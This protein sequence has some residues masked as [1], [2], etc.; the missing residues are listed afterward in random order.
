M[1]SKLEL[2]VNGL[3]VSRCNTTFG[4]LRLRCFQEKILDTIYKYVNNEI[5]EGTV[6]LS[7]PTGAGKTLTLLLGYKVFHEYSLRNYGSIGLYPTNELLNDQFKSIR[8]MLEKLGFAWRPYSDW[9]DN[10]LFKFINPED[11]KILVLVISGKKLSILEKYHPG[12][13]HTDILVDLSSLL[14]AEDP[15]YTVI[16]STPDLFYYLLLGIYGDKKRIVKYIQDIL[17]GVEPRITGLKDQLAR[18]GKILHRLAVKPLIFF[19]EYHSWSLLDYLSSLVLVKLFVEQ[20]SLVVLS[21]ATPLPET[22]RHL[23]GIGVETQAVIEENGSSSGDLIRLPTHLVVYGYSSSDARNHGYYGL[24]NIYNVEKL[25]PIHVKH[26]EDLVIDYARKNN[27][28]VLVVLDRISYTLETSR[29][30]G[31]KYGVENVAVVTGLLREGDPQRTLIVVGNRAIELGIDNPRAI[32]GI[33]TGKTFS[34]IIQRIGRIGRH[35]LGEA[36]ESYI[37]LVLSAGRLEELIDKTNGRHILGYNELLEILNEILP[38]EPK[39]TWIAETRYGRE[40]IETLLKTYYETINIIFTGGLPREARFQIQSKTYGLKRILSR[41]GDRI[42]D[43]YSLRTLSIDVK[44]MFKDGE[45]INEYD[46][47]TL[48]RNFEPVDLVT[49]GEEIIVF[50]RE[51]V[52]NPEPLTTSINPR[53]RHVNKLV[54]DTGLFNYIARKYL[55]RISPINYQPKTLRGE[56][57][58]IYRQEVIKHI[59]AMLSNE[60]ATIVL[61]PPSNVSKIFKLLTYTSTAIPVKSGEDVKGYILLGKNAL[62]PYILLRNNMVHG[63]DSIYMDNR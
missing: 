59:M 63:I 31:D 16:L 38:S 12:K 37:H 5:N 42:I 39:L 45:T 1:V 8:S 3:H 54:I 46:L 22:I 47:L 41:I 23:E 51:P 58:L 35:K 57:I 48:L 40:Y 9:R 6:Y 19:D 4:E 18:I 53:Y 15:D 33:I 32:A 34:S 28:Q 30:L 17:D 50:G 25:V 24:V 10:I 21:S 7:A 14:N 2:H 36:C 55:S 56:R 44:Y 49:R 60:P 26:E 61:N 62:L 20:G 52:T 27:G 11:E 13:T 29:V 43:V